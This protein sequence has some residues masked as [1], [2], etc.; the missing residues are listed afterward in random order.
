MSVAVNIS[1]SNDV[2]LLGMQGVQPALF[3]IAAQRLAW[4]SERQAVLAQNVANADTPGF[5][6]RDVTPFAQLLSHTAGSMARTDPGHLA[7]SSNTIIVTAARPSDR[8][9]DGNAVSIEQ[10]LTRIADTQTAQSLTSSLVQRYMAMF[11][12]TLGR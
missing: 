6:P 9:L 3:D 1:A 2:Y 8:A 4:T 7:E 11:R 12:I 5:T 10:E